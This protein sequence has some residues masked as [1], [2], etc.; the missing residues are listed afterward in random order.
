MAIQRDLLADPLDLP[1]D[2]AGTP[3]ARAYRREMRRV[4]PAYAWHWDDVKLDLLE[5][6]RVMGA[7]ESHPRPGAGTSLLGRLAG[8]GDGRKGYPAEKVDWARAVYTWPEAFLLSFGRRSEHDAVRLWLAVQDGSKNT[9]GD[10]A[11]AHSI[12]AARRRGLLWIA[13]ELMRDRRLNARERIQSETTEPSAPA[14]A[15][16]A[17]GTAWR[18][19]DTAEDAAA[20]PDAAGFSEIVEAMVHDARGAP[21]DPAA[22]VAALATR[23]AAEWF[24]DEPQDTVTMV[25]KTRLAARLKEAALGA[26][27]E[28]SAT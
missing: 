19:P 22:V 26:L 4:A 25:R 16:P 23:A 15:I 10:R 27:R 5:A 6:A 24:S 14:G 8:G 9:E 2:I 11:H 18:A 7:V 17:Y 12:R 13:A 28:T 1:K 3:A 21:G 20:M